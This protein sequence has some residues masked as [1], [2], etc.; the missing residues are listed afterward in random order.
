MATA[1]PYEDKLKQAGDL[2]IEEL[3]HQQF[4]SDLDKHTGCL[5]QLESD[6]DE[7]AHLLTMKDQI[8]LHG[9]TSSLCQDEG[10]HMFKNYDFDL[11]PFVNGSNEQLY[12]CVEG[13][14]SVIRRILLRIREI[15]NSIVEWFTT[16]SIFKYWM[17]TMY[18]Y[19][20][21]VIQLHYHYKNKI[22]RVD[23][24]IYN[25]QFLTGYD[26]ISW[27]NLTKAI[28]V[29]IDALKQISVPS[30]ISKITGKELEILNGKL[31]DCG[32]SLQGSHV[33]AMDAFNYR[34]DTVGALNWTLGKVMQQEQFLET[35]ILAKGLDLSRLGHALI[36][37]S[38][39]WSREIDRMLNAGSVDQMKLSN[40]QYMKDGCLLLQRL[41]RLV[42]RQSSGLAAQW[43]RMVRLIDTATVAATNPRTNY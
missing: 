33:Y 39:E 17:N 7:V 25:R 21:Q 26:F 5:E 9:V 41:T 40:A 12:Y 29:F 19:R 23:Q 34:R 42:M 14:G 15:F 36:R 10:E 24:T 11:N 28:S 27:V 1:F 6:L 30:D 8:L 13:L 2:C 31:A 20:K 22:Q 18:F 35:S 38:I 3:T 43:C 16:N 4:V 32:F 37:A